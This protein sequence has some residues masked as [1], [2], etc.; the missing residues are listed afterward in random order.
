MRIKIYVRAHVLCAAEALANHLRKLGH[1]AII[2]GDIDQNDTTLHIIYCAFAAPAIPNKY[3]V[4]Q[5]EVLNSKWFTEDY[6][7]ILDSALAIWDYD[8]RNV[9]LMP[10]KAHW[11]IP[12]GINHQKLDGM[13]DID[14]MHYG[15]INEHRRSLLNEI[16]DYCCVKIVEDVYGEEMYALLGRAKVVL[17]LHYYPHAPLEVFRIHEA[18]SYGC[19]V[20]SEPVDDATEKRHNG[21]VYFAESASDF[22]SRIDEAL[23][24]PFDYDL[25]SIDDFSFTA[26]K[27]AM[28]S[29]S[30][31]PS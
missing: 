5:T 13:R 29:I 7:R 10:S 14:V 4:Y 19:H 15:S 3:I 2:V 26:V 22:K 25:T 31:F 11:L 8:E 27:E 9:L 16:R 17:N 21:M 24:R 18:L 12:P 30:D 6:Q 23:N 1:E 28:K 20:I